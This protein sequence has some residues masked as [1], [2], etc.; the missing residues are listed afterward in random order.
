MRVPSGR[1]PGEGR[2]NLHQYSCLENPMDRGATVHRVAK[3]QTWPIDFA[4]THTHTHTC[5]PSCMGHTYTKISFAVYLKFKLKCAYLCFHCI[6]LAILSPG[7]SKAQAQAENLFPTWPTIL[8][9]A[10]AYCI[11]LCNLWGGWPIYVFLGPSV[12]W[13]LSSSP[14]VRLIVEKGGQIMRS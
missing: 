10:L 14:A 5:P 6:N 3:S 4:H 1:C 8:L 7:H 11:Q 12:A 2:G 9:S 13:C